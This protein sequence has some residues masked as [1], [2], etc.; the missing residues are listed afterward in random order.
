Y[1]FNHRIVEW[2]CPRAIMLPAIFPSAAPPRLADHRTLAMKRIIHI[3]DLHF[4]RVNPALVEPLLAIINQQQP[5]VVAVPGDLTQRATRD[6]FEEARRLLDRI[7]FPKVVVPGNH[8]ISLWNVYRRFA[9]PL[10][11]YRRHIGIEIEPIYV[12]DQL[13]VLGLN[14]ARS[15]TWKQG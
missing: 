13:F 7:L 8:D 2:P 5:N 15:L 9:R 3:S 10:E 4:G 12:D 14:T 1:S 11:R 6:Q